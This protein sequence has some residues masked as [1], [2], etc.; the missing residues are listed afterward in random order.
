MLAFAGYVGRVGARIGNENDPI[1][2]EARL[3]IKTAD[4]TLGWLLLDYSKDAP[5]ID[6]LHPL[7]G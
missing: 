4:G 1:C 3:L 5:S 7:A 2:T 6:G